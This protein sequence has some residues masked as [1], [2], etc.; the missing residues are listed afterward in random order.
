M[1]YV[2]YSVTANSDVSSFVRNVLHFTELV[3][4][5]MLLK[6]LQSIVILYK[7]A[8]QILLHLLLS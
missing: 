3:K 8:A 7:C 6:S 4:F 1:I 5:V 2:I